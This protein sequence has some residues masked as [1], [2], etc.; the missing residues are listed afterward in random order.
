MQADSGTHTD[1]QKPHFGVIH[2]AGIHLEYG[3]RTLVMGILNVTPDSFSDAG[4]TVT[5]AAAISA[6]EA[7]VAAGA[8][9]IDIGGESSRPGA[10]A[11]GLD[12]ELRRVLPVIEVLAPRLSVPISIDTTK[13]GVARR[14]FEAGARILNDISALRFDP[15]MTEIV[16]RA[17]VPVVLMHMQGT[18]RDMQAQPHY[19]DVVG[20]ICAF[21]EE[22]LRAAEQGGIPRERVILD[23]GI[24]FGKRLADNLE[25][26]RSLGRF[27]VFGRP[28]LV[29]ASRKAF[30]GEILDLP[31]DARLEGTA[32]AVAAAVLAGAAL[33]RVHDVQALVRVVRVAEAIRSGR[34]NP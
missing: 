30:I 1:D 34:T 11:V 20:E 2:G 33:V 22:R 9:V 32:A 29:G 24:G 27:H 16:A 21:F 13:A 12:E 15:E 8:D 3:H 17:G 6:A 10:S 5:M 19:A 23:P 31:V 18:P 25:I 4:R 28:L 26:L 7:M 14:A